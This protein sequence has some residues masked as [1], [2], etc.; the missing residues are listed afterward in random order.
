MCNVPIYFYNI[1]VYFCNTD[2]KH[3]Q[4]T[5][6]TPETLECNMHFSRNHLLVA[7]ASGGLSAH[8]GHCVLAGNA[9]LAGSV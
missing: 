8:G 4:H 6:E 9:E 7:S 2:T 1:P 5:S 3:L